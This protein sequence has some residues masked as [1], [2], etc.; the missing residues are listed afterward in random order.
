[1]QKITK[2]LYCM[3][4]IILSGFPLIFVY[5]VLLVTEKVVLAS[6]SLFQPA[7]GE[8]STCLLVEIHNSCL[9]YLF[10]CFETW[11]VPRFKI[12]VFN[13]FRFWLKRFLYC[14]DDAQKDVI[15]KW[16]LIYLQKDRPFY[17]QKNLF[18]ILQIAY[19][20]TGFSV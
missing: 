20:S 6:E 18:Y 17:T 1:M 5:F 11:K 13:F 2:N 10:K 14:Q 3:F 9:K 7:N 15:L 12:L 19:F 16:G 4:C 8:R